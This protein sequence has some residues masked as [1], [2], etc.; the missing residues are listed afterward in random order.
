VISAGLLTLPKTAKGESLDDIDVAIALFR[1][2]IRSFGYR[3][4]PTA[5]GNSYAVARVCD[6]L[7]GAKFFYLGRGSAAQRSW[8]FLELLRQAG[9]KGVMLGTVGRDGSYLPWLPA[10]LVGGEAY[11]FEPTYGMPVPSR[12]G[13][14][15]ATVREAASD[16]T[17]AEPTGRHN[18]AIPGRLG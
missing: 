16:A 7:S 12:A 15:V 11:L 1:W 4:R 2:T 18:S 13:S 6:G 8:I 17:C 10:V 9:L 14:G 5:V 3:K